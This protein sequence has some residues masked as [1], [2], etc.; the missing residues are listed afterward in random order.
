[1]PQY[2]T[3]KDRENQDS[4]QVILEDC[5]FIVKQTGTFTTND[6]MLHW[7]GEPYAIAEYKFRAKRYDPVKVDC[8]KIDFLLEK[9]KELGVK[10]VL[11]YSFGNITPINFWVC[12]G[13]MAVSTL[14]RKKGDRGDPKTLV[15]EIPSNEWGEI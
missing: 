11:L 4:A 5:G 9:S 12:R 15:Y 3:E 10:P 1:M 8:D 13:G 14:Q 2:E 7:E 6:M